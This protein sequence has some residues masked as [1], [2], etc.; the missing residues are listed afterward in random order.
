MDPE[1][2]G[3]LRLFGARWVDSVQT[4][5]SRDDHFQF[6]DNPPIDGVIQLVFYGQVSPTGTVQSDAP[7]IVHNAEP[8]TAS[9]RTGVLHAEPTFG[10]ESDPLNR[11]DSV[12]ITLLNSDNKS[13]GQIRLARAASCRGAS[14]EISDKRVAEAI[15]KMVNGQK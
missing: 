15:K 4:N 7:P 13:I 6:Y 8:T 12:N 10:L 3:R 1:P 14:D 11:I 2:G 9:Q 5:L